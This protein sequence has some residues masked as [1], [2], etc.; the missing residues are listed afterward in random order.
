MTERGAGLAVIAAAAGKSIASGALVRLRHGLE[1]LTPA[2]QR[3][4]RYAAEHPEAV[5]YQTV[6]ELADA[7]GAGEASVI[8]ACRDLGY[9]GF[10]DFKLALAVDLAGRGVAQPE[11]AGAVPHDTIGII[12]FAAYVSKEAL[13]A[14]AGILD[15]DAVDRVT[16]A[17]GSAPRIE[18]YGVGASGITAQDFAYKFLRLGLP[19]V[20]ILDPH[21]AAMSAANLPAGAV[22]IGISRSGSTMDTI[23]ALQTARAVGAYTVALTHRARSAITFADAILYTSSPESPL[24]GGAVSSKV[25]QLLVLEVLFTALML[26]MPSAADAVRRTAQA[27][28]DKSL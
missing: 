16:A 24:S 7:S 17:I 18:V 9:S 12:N 1:A 14:T 4:A 6:T 19:V 27:V 15:P 28:A 26:R 11:A 20:A 2:L 22:A 13:D 23:V 8:R 3:V 25:G 5:I 10:Q 21:L